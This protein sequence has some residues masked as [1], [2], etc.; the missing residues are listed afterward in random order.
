VILKEVRDGSAS[1]LIYELQV[2]NSLLTVFI[3]MLVNRTANMVRMATEQKPPEAV[4]NSESYL[5]LMN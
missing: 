1:L 3:A 2:M 5:Y 4:E